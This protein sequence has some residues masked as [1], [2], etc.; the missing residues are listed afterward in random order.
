MAHATA[1]QFPGHANWAV[2][3]HSAHWSTALSEHKK[4]LVY[5]TADAA[6]EI[7]SLDAS[8][9]YIIGG[10][11]DRNQHKKI[12]LNRAEEHGIRTARLPLGDSLQLTGSKVRNTPQQFQVF[13]STIE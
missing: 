3:F 5:L 13:I 2:N 6:E 7:I 4:S 11:V 10:L 12:C 1:R 9:Y 8:C